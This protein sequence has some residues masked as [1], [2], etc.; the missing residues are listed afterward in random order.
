MN[1]NKELIEEFI[2]KTKRRRVKS[3]YPEFFAKEF[4][5]SKDDTIDYLNRFSKESD[6]IKTVYEVRCPDCL[7]VIEEYDDIL[8]LDTEKSIECES[9]NSEVIVCSSSIYI[10]Y[11]IN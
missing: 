1:Y 11:C 10:K 6:K 2:N 7:D 9:C 5:L 8:S 4:S 3:F